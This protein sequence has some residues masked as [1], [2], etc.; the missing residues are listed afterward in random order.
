M[1][2]SSHTTRKGS[3]MARKKSED[4]PA[5]AHSVLGVMCSAPTPPGV[6][7][8]APTRLIEIDLFRFGV[9]CSTLWGAQNMVRSVTLDERGAKALMHELVK[10]LIV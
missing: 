5:A 2:G 1:L 4:A 6:K 7:I 3:L 9:V 10:A 8:G